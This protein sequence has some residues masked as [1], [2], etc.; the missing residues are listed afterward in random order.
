M[1]LKL[2]LTLAGAQLGALQPPFPISPLHEAPP[3][4]TK[5]YRHIFQRS[6]ETTLTLSLLLLEGKLPYDGADG[7]DPTVGKAK[8]TLA[9]KMHGNRANSTLPRKRKAC[10][11]QTTN[12]R[13]TPGAPTI[14][15]APPTQKTPLPP[16]SSSRGSNCFRGR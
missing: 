12:Y 10:G 15:T 5:E 4:P 1:A 11:D 6:G 8:P 9:A 14:T 13:I 16:L 3:F 2:A 7:N